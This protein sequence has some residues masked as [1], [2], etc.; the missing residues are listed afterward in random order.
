M[1]YTLSPSM[2]SADFSKIG[3][4][5]ATLEEAGV[6]W[7]HMDVMDGMF[8]PNLALGIGEIKSLRKCTKLFFDVHLMV[9]EPIR[10][11]DRFVDAGS[12]LIT[13]HYEACKDLDATIAK[14]REAGLKCGVSIKPKTPVEVLLPYLDQID[15]ILLMSVEPG[16]GGQSYIPSSTE[17]LREIRRMIRDCGRDIDLEIDGGINKETVVTALDAGANVIVAGSAVFK[18]DLYDTAKYYNDLVEGYNRR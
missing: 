14:I 2:L 6:R 3:E 17:R 1:R 5:F 13:V 16:F 7:I 18:E 4:Q 10:Y 9:Q 12:E 8:V 11:I 15:L